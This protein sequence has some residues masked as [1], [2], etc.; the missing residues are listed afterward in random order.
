MSVRTIAAIATLTL[1]ASVAALAGCGGAD[2][3]SAS[4]RASTS[5]PGPAASST[6][7]AAVAPGKR[8][9]L[10]TTLDGKRTLPARVRWIARP[11]GKASGAPIPGR[12]RS[13]ITAAFAKREQ[14]PADGFAGIRRPACITAFHH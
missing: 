5:S 1:V 7:P 3:D 14:A 8:A 10:T 9:K 11:S 13:A 6:A 12:S 4:A 2:P